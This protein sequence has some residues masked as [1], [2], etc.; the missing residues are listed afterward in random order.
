MKWRGKGA[1]GLEA[2]RAPTFPPHDDD[3]THR[4]LHRS[5]KDERTVTTACPQPG[6]ENGPQRLRRTDTRATHHG[7]EL[8]SNQR[9]NTFAQTY[10]LDRTP[11]Q[12]C[13]GPYIL[14]IRQR[15]RC[16]G[17]VQNEGFAYLHTHFVFWLCSQ[18]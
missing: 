9:P 16:I 2:L 3:F 7:Q 17:I 10:L 5:S 14:G 13:G 12:S 11:L 1:Y 18:D 8:I 6:P 15:V 4:G